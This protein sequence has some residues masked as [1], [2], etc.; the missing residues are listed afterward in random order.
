MFYQDIVD[1]STCVLFLLN[2]LIHL[3]SYNCKYSKTRATQKSTAQYKLSK[4]KSK[5][6]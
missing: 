2:I 6:K 1:K 5:I 3:F 4:F